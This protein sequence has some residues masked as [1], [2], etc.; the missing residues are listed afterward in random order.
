MDT[1]KKTILLID[2]DPET[3]QLI[4]EILEMADYVV[5]SATDGKQGI[6]LAIENPPDLILCDVMMPVLDGLGVLHIVRKNHVLRHIPFIFLTSLT[7]EAE[8]RKGMDLGADDYIPKPTNSTVLLGAIESRLKKSGLFQHDMQSNVGAKGAGIAS[9]TDHL[10]ELK[11]GRDIN[12]YVKKQLIYSEGNHPSKLYYITKG[13]VKASKRGADGRELIVQLYRQGDFLGYKAVFENGI[14]HET[15]EALED[16]FLTI[17]PISEFNDLLWRHPEVMKNFL[18][19]LAKQI[20]YSEERLVSMAYHSL[21]KK[22]ADTLLAVC[23]MYDIDRSD[24]FRID[25]S[26][27]TLASMAGVAKE[28]LIRTLS[29]FRSQGLVR[30]DGGEIYILDYSGLEHLYN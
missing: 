1:D 22:V 14:Y 24:S 4:S 5:H 11:R 17:I 12:H 18:K 8:M 3:R 28:S 2:D 23:K 16:T 26:R 29:D 25:M 13:R 6:N 7:D 9:G 21:R 10:E 19:I 15:A 27:E 20:H 30:I